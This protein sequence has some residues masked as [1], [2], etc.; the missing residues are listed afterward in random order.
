MVA[1]DVILADT[2]IH[3]AFA[4]RN[5]RRRHDRVSMGGDRRGS[6]GVRAAFSYGGVAHFGGDDGVFERP[7]PLA[8]CASL[9][10]ADGRACVG[11][12][13]ERSAPFE[14]PPDAG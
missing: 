2:E 3:L 13:R 12:L 1:D 10:A 5:R 8:G 7:L 9:R 6:T 14:F 4:Y 11:S